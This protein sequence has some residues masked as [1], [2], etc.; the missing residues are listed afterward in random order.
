M[1]F[2]IHTEDGIMRWNE[3]FGCNIHRFMKFLVVWKFA[4]DLILSIVNIVLLFSLYIFTTWLLQCCLSWYEKHLGKIGYVLSFSCCNNFF[5]RQSIVHFQ[6]YPFCHVV[7]IF[8]LA[9]KWNT[10]PQ[11]KNLNIFITNV[12]WKWWSILYPT[13]V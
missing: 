9:S 10:K 5:I 12:R 4:I 6:S 3:I 11:A 7:L 8:T 2:F 1:H 13:T